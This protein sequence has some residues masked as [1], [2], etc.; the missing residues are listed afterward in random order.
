MGWKVLEKGVVTD[1][2]APEYEQSDQS[3]HHLTQVMQ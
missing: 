1:Q 3:L 2:A